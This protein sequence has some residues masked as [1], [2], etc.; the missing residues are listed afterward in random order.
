MGGFFAR[1]LTKSRQQSW[2]AYAVRTAFA[3]TVGTE[4]GPMVA[5]RILPHGRRGRKLIRTRRLPQPQP[6][7]SVLKS[8]SFR[9][10]ASKMD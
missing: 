4:A 5:D 7:F 8:E 1:F 3:G 2:S 10:A 9:G 6:P